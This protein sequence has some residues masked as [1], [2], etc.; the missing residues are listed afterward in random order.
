MTLADIARQMARASSPAILTAE[1]IMNKNYDPLFLI[2]PGVIPQGVTLLVASPKM[3]KSF[4]CLQLAVAVAGGGKMLGIDVE[5]HEVL[6]LALEDTEQRVNDRLAKMI[7]GAPVPKQLHIPVHWM[8]GNGSE[9]DRLRTWL[10]EHPRTKLIIID[11]LVKFS[12]WQ[13]GNY[14]ADYQHISKF[15]ALADR[16]KIALILVHHQRKT[17]AKDECDR[18]VGSNGDRSSQGCGIIS[19]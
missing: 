19:A 4:F 15:K 5:A 3:V 13:Q 9:F 18:V 14:N 10:Q 8:Q 7:Q 1:Q 2:V 16:Y 12:S 17:A 11:T 6:Y